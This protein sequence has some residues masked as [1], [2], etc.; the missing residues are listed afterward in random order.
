MTTTTATHTAATDRDRQVAEEIARQI[1]GRAFFMMGTT[2]KNIDG[3]GLTFN[4]KGSKAW[5]KIRVRLDA[6]D[7][8]NILFLKIGRAPSFKMTSKNYQGFMADDLHRIIEQETGLYLS[9]GTM[10]GAAR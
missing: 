4:V 1:G 5:N 8:Y 10:K 3:P 7:T 6:D 2:Q 9:L